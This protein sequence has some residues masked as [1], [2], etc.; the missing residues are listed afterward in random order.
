MK[1]K[2][3]QHG[4]IEKAAANILLAN[5]VRQIEPEHVID[6]PHGISDVNAYQ[7][8][9]FNEN[10]KWHSIGSFTIHVFISRIV[11]K[12]VIFAHTHHLTSAEFIIMLKATPK[13]TVVN[14]ENIENCTSIACAR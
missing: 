11:E 1:N 9:Q 2:R 4:V 12:I 7:S 5:T 13:S 6:E 14:N 3:V 10:G 8:E